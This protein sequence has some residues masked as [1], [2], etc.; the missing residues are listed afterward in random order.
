M[1]IVKNITDANQVNP[2]DEYFIDAYNTDY[3]PLSYD[4][5]LALR[6]QDHIEKRLE[7]KEKLDTIDILI[8]VNSKK[9][10]KL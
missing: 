2:G 8:N 5:D 9:I 7:I 3:D 4:Y 6:L 10:K 1:I